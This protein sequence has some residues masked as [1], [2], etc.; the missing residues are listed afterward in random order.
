MSYFLKMLYV[1][2]RF[3]FFSFPFQLFIRKSDAK[4]EQ[5]LLVTVTRYNEK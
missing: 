5:N 1:F 3:K 4:R 2:N